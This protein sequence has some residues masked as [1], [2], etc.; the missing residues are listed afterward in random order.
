MLID[1][2]VCMMKMDS[3]RKAAMLA[4]VKELLNSKDFKAFSISTLQ[5]AGLI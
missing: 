4:D 1:L 3:S 5:V 2:K